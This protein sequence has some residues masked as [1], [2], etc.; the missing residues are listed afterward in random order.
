M[1]EKHQKNAKVEND[2]KGKSIYFL[3]EKNEKHKKFAIHKKMH[4]KPVTFQMQ[5]KCN[6]YKT[7]EALAISIR[8][9]VENCVF[10]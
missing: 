4:E 6:F 8:A 7:E 2:R 5:R 1:M 9:G 10:S 3:N